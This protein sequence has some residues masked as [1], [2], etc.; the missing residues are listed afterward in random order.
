MTQQ[1]NIQL[2]V[3]EIN[4]ILAALQELPAKVCNP[5]TKKIVEQAEPQVKP[6]TEKTLDLASGVSAEESFN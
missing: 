5:L 6:S 2:T 3:D 1:I 4:M